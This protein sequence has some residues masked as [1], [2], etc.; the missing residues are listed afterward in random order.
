MLQRKASSHKFISAKNRLKPLEFMRKT[1]KNSSKCSETNRKAKAIREIEKNLQ[2]LKSY[3][4]EEDTF[5]SKD[6]HPHKHKL[7]RPKSSVLKKAPKIE[8]D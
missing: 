7:S 6:S 2:L 5:H 4:Q 1:V 3:L 8:E